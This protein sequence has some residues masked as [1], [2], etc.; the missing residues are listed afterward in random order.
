VDLF[1]FPSILP[2]FAR[3]NGHGKTKSGLLLTIMG[4]VLIPSRIIGGLLVD[5]FV[6]NPLLSISVIVFVM[7]GSNLIFPFVASSYPALAAI[8]GLRGFLSGVSAAA[9]PGN[10]VLL[11]TTDR[12]TT[13]VG[14]NIMALGLG[15]LIAPPLG[16]K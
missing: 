4:A 11:F 2:D 8:A 6:L 13:A 15:Q 10:L 16:G 14:Y 3:L 9:A 5:R 1:N 7:G 12:L